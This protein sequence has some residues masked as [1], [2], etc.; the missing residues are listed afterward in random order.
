MPTVSRSPSLPPQRLKRKYC[1]ADLTPKG[2]LV[3]AEAFK[4]AVFE[5]GETRKAPRQ[6]K[7]FR[8]RTSKRSCAAVCWPAAANGT[9]MA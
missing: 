1:L 2:G 7:R 9:P 5:I 6:F 3:P 4:G 8:M